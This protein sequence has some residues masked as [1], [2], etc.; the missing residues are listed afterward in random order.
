MT[1]TC[2]G[3]LVLEMNGACWS[4]PQFRGQLERGTLLRTFSHYL[5]VE[6]NS[7]QDS[8]E[9]GMDKSVSALEVLQE[10][11]FAALSAKHQENRN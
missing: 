8:L 5:E 1:G 2:L 4:L 3:A 7:V 10:L 6:C 11:A 9:G